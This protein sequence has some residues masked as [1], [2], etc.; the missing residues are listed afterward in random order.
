MVKM[1]S[2][3]GSEIDAN[4]KNGTTDKRANMANWEMV[5]WLNRQGRRN[6][7]KVKNWQRRKLTQMVNK[8]KQAVKSVKS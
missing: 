7:L 5:K 1:L 8:G 2:P 3:T 6:M 4:A